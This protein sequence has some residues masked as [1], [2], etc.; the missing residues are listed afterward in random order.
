MLLASQTKAEELE[1]VVNWSGTHACL[2]KVKTPESR[3]EAIRIVAEHASRN[4]RIR[5]VGGALSPNGLAFAEDGSTL[6]NLALLDKVL[7]VD[8]EKRTV[9]VEAGCRVEQVLK[10]LGTA[11]PDAGEFSVNSSTASRRLR[12]RRRARDGG[13]PAARR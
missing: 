12:G 4:E 6:I 10:K 11:Q 8:V 3:K 5:P 2:C 9:T 7:D 1:E 13:V